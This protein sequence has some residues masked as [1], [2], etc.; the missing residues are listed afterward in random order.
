MAERL[1]GRSA[2]LAVKVGGRLHASGQLMTLSPFLAGGMHSTDLPCS[3]FLPPTTHPASIRAYSQS[4]NDHSYSTTIH[5]IRNVCSLRLDLLPL[6]PSLII[7]MPQADT[8]R[9]H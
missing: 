5:V 6:K 9:E 7:C 8:C 1:V 4:S 2:V 3:V